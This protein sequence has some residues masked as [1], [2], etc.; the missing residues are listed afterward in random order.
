M[1]ELSVP[2]DPLA[3]KES[4]GRIET[5]GFSMDQNTITII[6]VIVF[7]ALVLIVHAVQNSRL[8]D[9]SNK[10]VFHAS[11]LGQEN[12]LKPGPARA[13]LLRQSGNVYRDLGEF[14]SK[15]LAIA[16]VQRSFAR[17]KIDGIA[18]MEN[19]SSRLHIVRML[20]ENGGKSEGRKLGG[21]IIESMA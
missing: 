2:L 8:E 6:A 11:Q 15:E 17:A 14:E 18:V 9:S 16:D 13:V 5:E 4:V 7:V 20:R 3:P 1:K 21:A 10:D 19:S 12:T